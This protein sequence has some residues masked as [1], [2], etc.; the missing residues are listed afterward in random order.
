MIYGLIQEYSLN[1]YHEVVELQR[2]VFEA[3]PRRTMDNLPVQKGS[4]LQPH[5]KSESNKN[6]NQNENNGSQ[7]SNNNGHNSNY[8]SH[9]GAIYQGA[10]IVI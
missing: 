2:L 4:W 3:R 5:Q 6:K 8:C 7:N 9:N 10:R 1:C